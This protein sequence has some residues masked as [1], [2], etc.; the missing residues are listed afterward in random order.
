MVGAHM[1][2]TKKTMMS[3]TP[4]RPS[5][6]NGQSSAGFDI[7]KDVED[8]CDRFQLIFGSQ[9]RVNKDELVQQSLQK[10]RDVRIFRAYDFG[11]R[12]LQAPTV[13]CAHTSQLKDCRAWIDEDDERKL[14]FISETE[15]TA[16][17]FE[18]RGY[19]EYLKHSITDVSMVPQKA[20]R[21]GNTPGLN[22]MVRPAPS[23]TKIP[24][25]LPPPRPGM[26]LAATVVEQFEDRIIDIENDEVF[27]PICLWTKEA[28]KKKKV[29]SSFYNRLNCYYAVK[30]L[31]SGENP[32]DITKSQKELINMARQA[33]VG[34]NKGDSTDY[35][36]ETCLQL[37]NN[38]N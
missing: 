17:E 7:I 22:V 34:Q 28:R 21:S 32:N 35:W 9:D 29:P 8:A 23:E 30:K 13:V 31:L 15:A 16:Q 25:I 14:V 24:E 19:V 27:S 10:L 33:A 20:R 38:E 5:Q 2:L 1:P 26:T 18:R 6:Q 3:G 37:F 4:M 11:D 36:Y 12:E